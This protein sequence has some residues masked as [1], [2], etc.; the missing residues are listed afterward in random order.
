MPK[1][2]S[3]L[4]GSAQ[5]ESGNFY[6]F[7]ASVEFEAPEGEFKHVPEIKL[8]KGASKKTNKAKK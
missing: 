3:T 2:V 8:V 1:Y 4:S 7:T 6:R 5:G